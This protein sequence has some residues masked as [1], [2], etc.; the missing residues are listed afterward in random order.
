MFV[1]P[2]L[3]NRRVCCFLLGGFVW[4]FRLCFGVSTLAFL[5]VI[6]FSGVLFAISGVEIFGFMVGFD[7]IW[8]VPVDSWCGK[9]VGRSTF[10]IFW[11]A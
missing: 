3:L 1:V 9:S 6:L 10:G 11:G 2:V 5:S 7:F 8:T 4:G